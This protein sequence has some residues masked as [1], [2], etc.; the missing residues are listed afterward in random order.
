MF[1]MTAMNTD[2][3]PHWRRIRLLKWLL[4]SQIAVSCAPTPLLAPSKPPRVVQSKNPLS[5]QATEKPRQLIAVEPN[6]GAG[7]PS[8]YDVAPPSP[9]DIERARLLMQRGINHY[10]KGEY[11]RAEDFLKE[12][13]G[14]YPFSAQANVVLGKV[15]LIRGS[16]ERDAA[17]INSAR[18]MFEM[19]HALDPNLREPTMLLELFQSPPPK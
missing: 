7:Q 6:P 15:L 8:P 13:M 10:Q 3:K 19:A 1:R 11:K 18:L 14:Y 5:E 4:L 12:S 9:E 16:A 17:C 2:A